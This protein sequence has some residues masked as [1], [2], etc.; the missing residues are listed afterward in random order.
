MQ[1]R[2]LVSAV[3]EGDVTLEG[4][5]VEV[6]HGVFEKFMSLTLAYGKVLTDIGRTQYAFLSVT[7]SE[8][9]RLHPAS[10]AHSNEATWEQLSSRPAMQSQWADRTLPE[11]S[12]MTQGVRGLSDIL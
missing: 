3:S 11:F 2:K 9:L 10:M 7:V 6:E 5:T 12:H 1:L 4:L 8:S